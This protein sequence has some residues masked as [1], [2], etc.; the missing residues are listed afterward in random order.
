MP[1]DTIK[2]TIIIISYVTKNITTNGF[3]IKNVFT[4]LLNHY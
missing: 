2:I 4:Y 1:I 3:L